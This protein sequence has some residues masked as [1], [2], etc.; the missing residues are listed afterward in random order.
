MNL[1]EHNDL[2]YLVKV[3]EPFINRLHI[4]KVEKKN[5]QAILSIYLLMPIAPSGA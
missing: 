5:T 1:S 4:L 2:P 3:N